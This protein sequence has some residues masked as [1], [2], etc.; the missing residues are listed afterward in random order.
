MLHF[1][2]I[3]GHRGK[4]PAMQDAMHAARHLTKSTMTG[5]ADGSAKSPELHS[6]RVGRIEYFFLDCF[7]PI[8]SLRIKFVSQSVPVAVT[9]SA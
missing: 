3:P 8:A 9:V 1:D 4:L 5:S 6:K 7:W 2:G